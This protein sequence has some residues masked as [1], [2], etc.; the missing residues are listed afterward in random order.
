MVTP[1]PPRGHI[2]LDGV[3]NRSVRS[4]KAK[5][6]KNTQSPFRHSAQ[7]ALVGVARGRAATEA[8]PG[9]GSAAV[10]R[11][12]GRRGWGQVGRVTGVLTVARRVG[13]DG[14]GAFSVKRKKGG[15]WREAKWRRVWVAHAYRWRRFGSMR[16]GGAGGLQVGAGAGGRAQWVEGALAAATAGTNVGAS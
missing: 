16:N 3:T 1:L 9:R 13:S 12:C 14:G 5:I 6:R 10:G 11:G 15:S 4:L 7:R 8:R 2:N